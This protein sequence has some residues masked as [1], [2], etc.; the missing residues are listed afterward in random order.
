MDRRPF[1]SRRFLAARLQSG[2]E[3]CT[4]GW[5]GYSKAALGHWS[6]AL[7]PL[8]THVIHIRRAFGNVKAW[9]KGTHRGVDPRDPQI[10]LDEFVVRLNRRK[11]PVTA[12]RTL[13]G[14][15]APKQPAGYMK[16][17]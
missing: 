7:H 6:H 11:P 13:S 5:K 3:I 1:N 14:L 17:T 2:S 4:D 16:I 8:E 10:Q 15:A 12:L 9:L